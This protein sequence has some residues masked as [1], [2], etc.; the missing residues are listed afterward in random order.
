MQTKRQFPVFNSSTFCSTMKLL[1][2]RPIC[3]AVCISKWLS[4]GL[5]RDHSL[6]RP[7]ARCYHPSIDDIQVNFRHITIEE[8]IADLRVYWALCSGI[9]FNPHREAITLGEIHLSRD[10]A[11]ALRAA[12]KDADNCN[13]KKLILK[14]IFPHRACGGTIPEQLASGLRDKSNVDVFCN[15]L[16]S[17]R[18]CT[19]EASKRNNISSFV[20]GALVASLGWR[21]CSNGEGTWK[22]AD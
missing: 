14:K 20:E 22:G 10:E 3:S 18:C 1:M 19:G 16:I 9:K 7:T 21:R 5:A 8:E 17:L 15:R 13:L 4:L 6:W 2:Q 11:A 12:L